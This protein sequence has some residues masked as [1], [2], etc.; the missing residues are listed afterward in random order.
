LYQRI[1]GI[2]VDKNWPT[3]A[4]D[5]HIAQLIMEEYAEN[6]NK[7]ALGLFELVVDQQEKKM[8]FRLA[9]WVVILAQ[10]FNSMYGSDQG[11]F[12]T[13]QVIRQCLTQG[14]TLH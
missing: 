6:E 12:V 5:M 14:Q 9:N 3:K 13:R 1:E 11:D 7:D 10:Q 4:K 2:F 8:N